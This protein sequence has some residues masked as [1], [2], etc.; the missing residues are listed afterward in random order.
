MLAFL[1]LI[2]VCRHKKDIFLSPVLKVLWALNLSIR[3]C[4]GNQPEH[5]A[6]P[7]WSVPLAGPWHHGSGQTRVLRSHSSPRMWEC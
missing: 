5:L 6:L 3:V 4:L 7:L 1:V 2:R